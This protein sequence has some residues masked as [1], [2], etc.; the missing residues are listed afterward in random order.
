MEQ[1]IIERATLADIKKLQEIGRTTFSE[2]F[3][4]ANTEEN[5]KEYLEKGFSEEKLTGELSNQ[6]SQFYFALLDGKVIG[7]LKINTGQAQTEKLN[8][9]ALEIE[10]IYILKAF[11]GQKVGQLLYQKAIDIAHEI[12]ASYVWLGVWEENHRAL[13]FY[14]KNGFI[15]FNKHKFWLGDDEQTDLMMKKV[16]V[17]KNELKVS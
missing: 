1:I 17:N 4:A 9:D 15:A 3:A 13:R 10:R 11:Y 12:R 5:M 16:L 7:Y 2:A 8:L 14:E 6:D